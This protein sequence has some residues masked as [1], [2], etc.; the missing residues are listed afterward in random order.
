[1]PVI[2][3]FLVLGFLGTIEIL[4]LVRPQKQFAYTTI[5]F[6]GLLMTSLIFLVGGF[7][8]FSTD[9]KVINRLMVEPAIWLHDNT[10]R[11]SIIAAHD[12][13]AIGFFSERK[14][15]DLAGLID[16]TVVPIIRDENQL[17]RYIF[18]S[19]AD[20]LVVFS[21][22]YEDLGNLGSLEKEYSVNL[23]NLV[24]TVEIRNLP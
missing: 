23:G 10:E 3:V 8:S 1:M 17:T 6:A 5:I 7:K 9:V 12:I 21:D 13:G 16:P 19:G 20:Y 14:I 2:P 18:E 11:D 24:K 15:I 22:W 4:A